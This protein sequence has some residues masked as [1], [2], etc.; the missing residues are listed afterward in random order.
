MASVD[1]SD[2]LKNRPHRIV[3]AGTPDTD[4]WRILGGIICLCLLVVALAWW[5][6]SLNR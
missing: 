5:V 2:D 4:A 1:Q 6:G 3:K